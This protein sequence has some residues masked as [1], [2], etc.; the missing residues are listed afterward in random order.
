MSVA[1]IPIVSIQDNNLT[2]TSLSIA[3]GVQVQHKNIVG[4]IRK[5]SNDLEEFGQLAFETRV[6]SSGGAGQQ[7]EIAILNEQQATILLTYMRNSEI[8]RSFKIALV[9][10]FYE[11]RDQLKQPAID[12][13][14]PRELRGLLLSYSDKVEELED[15]VKEQL[16]KVA[17]LDRISTADGYTCITNAAKTLQIRPKDLFKALSSNRWI[18]R[19]AGGKTWIGYQAKIQQG[20]L[21]HKVVTILLPDGSERLQEQVLVTAKGMAKLG[22]LFTIALAKKAAR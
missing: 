6:V 3:E 21:T 16:P 14:N 13:M 10:A 17:A 2:T 4:L 8:V 5:Y 15:T 1:N 18:Y 19:R 20:Y 12:L 22:E 11:M 7:T 9:K